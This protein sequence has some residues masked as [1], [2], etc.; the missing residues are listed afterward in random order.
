VSVTRCVTAERTLLADLRAGCHAPLGAW[1][2]LDGDELTLTAVLLS[3]NGEHRL[4]ATETGSAAEPESI[5]SAVAR[6]LL[7]AGGEELVRT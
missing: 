1:T 5:G 4:E 3:A 6:A 7:T 2:E